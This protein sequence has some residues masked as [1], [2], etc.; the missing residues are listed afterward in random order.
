MTQT[1]V[2][3]VLPSHLSQRIDSALSAIRNHESFLLAGRGRLNEERLKGKNV[4]GWIL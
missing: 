2:R 4:N 1:S 3:L